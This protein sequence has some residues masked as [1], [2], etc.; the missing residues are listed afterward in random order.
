MLVSFHWRAKAVTVYQIK[1][2]SKNYKN[3]KCALNRQLREASHVGG[4]CEHGAGMNAVSRHLSHRLQRDR[5]RHRLGVL[6]IGTGSLRLVITS[7]H[8]HLTDTQ[9]HLLTQITRDQ[10][11]DLVL[12]AQCPIQKLLALAEKKCLETGCCQQKRS[13]YISPFIL[14]I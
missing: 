1:K 3:G 7:V 10:T 12:N 14:I 8:H 9:T 5:G 11:T 13:L 2:I 6:L 4:R